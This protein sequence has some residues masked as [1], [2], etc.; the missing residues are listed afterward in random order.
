MMRI[1]GLSFQH[2]A[3]LHRRGVGAQNMAR[4][5]GLL[6]D[7]K[8]VVHLPRGMIGRDVELGEIVIVEFDVG[9]LGNG[10]A[11]IGE[12][13][14]YFVQHLAHRVDGASGLG[15]HGQGD[16]DALE[17]QTRIQGFRIESGFACRDG[18]RHAVAQPIEQWSARLARIGR[19][20]AQALQQ[21]ADEALF[22]QRRHAQGFQCLRVRGA[23]NVAQGLAFEGFYIA[24]AIPQSESA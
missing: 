4:A 13:R 8:R 2:G 16:V 19:H 6:G 5:V 17:S 3:H 12:D 21:F 20:C 22:A 24:H 7:I 18:A 1:G 11:E 14:G 10:E 23:R 15:T 9:T